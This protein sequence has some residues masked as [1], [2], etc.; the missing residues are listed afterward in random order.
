VASSRCDYA[1]AVGTL[2][3]APGET[4][5]TFPLIVVDDAFVE[6]PESLTITL[7][8][9]V[10]INLGT[11]RTAIVTITDN[12]TTAAVP[13]PIDSA[14]FFI[15]QHYV[16]FLNR[17]PD[18]PGYAGWQNI[19]NNCAPGNTSCDRI[20]VSS[21]FFRSPEFRDRGYY[22]FKLYAASLGRSP[23]YAEFIPDLAK[24]SGFLS[25]S[26]LDINKSALAQEFIARAEFDNIY[27][28][29]TNQQYVDKLLM[30]A[31][32]T[33]PQRSG[34]IAALDANTK[35]RA[36]VLREFAESPEVD[37]K[38]FVQSFVVMQY[39]G[40]LRRDPDALYTVWI[41]MMMADPNNY[42][43]MVNGFV[44]SLEYRQRFGN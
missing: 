1:T 13:N 17:E 40:Y 38:F 39:F 3:F 7:S 19:L 30:T 31:G 27:Q 42:R 9:P 32:V 22:V 37:S 11:Q 29:T 36:Q 43:A 18:P 8:N 24:V 16:D 20:E 6:G 10:G 21:A 23:L 14:S 35:T 26:E 12:D 44:N 4:T 41:Q 2:R 5:K 33:S 15:R 34:W 28:G 25:A